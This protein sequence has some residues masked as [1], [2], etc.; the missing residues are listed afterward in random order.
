MLSQ[1]RL[2]R[3]FE[4]RSQPPENTLSIGTLVPI[5]KK[6]RNLRNYNIIIT[7]Y[8]YIIFTWYGEIIPS[9]I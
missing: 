6:I 1:F 2:D 7:V 8:N 5:R 4:I 9:H 3:L